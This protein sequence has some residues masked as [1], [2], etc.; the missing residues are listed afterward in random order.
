M[1]EKLINVYVFL[2]GRV[3]F[4][5]LNKLLY[6]LSLGGLG[7]LNYRTSMVSGEKSFLEKYLSKSSGIIVD[8]GANEGCYALEALGFR[9]DL[10]I[11]AF[12]PHPVTYAALKNN[13][14]P[15][16]N[17]ITIN[18]GMSS[19]GGVINLYDYPSKDGSCHASLFQDVITEIH[20]SGSAVAHEVSLTTID[21]FMESE[22]I[23]EMIF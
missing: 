17:V 19:E 13:V 10:K 5:R 16:Q 21:Q 22:G 15:S 11:Y 6:R 1:L 4:Q 20:G 7:I 18:Q 23:L 8:V 14:G 3:R 9:Q 12:E 2:F